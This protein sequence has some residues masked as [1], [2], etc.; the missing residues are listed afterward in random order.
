MDKLRLKVLACLLLGLFIAPACKK[1]TST[2]VSAKVSEAQPSSQ[3]SVSVFD[4]DLEAFIIDED[5]SAFGP[6]DGFVLMDESEND[7]VVEQSRHG[8][9]PIYFEFDADSMKPAQ[10]GA[11]ENNLARAKKL[12]AQ[13]KKI[14]IEGHACKFAGSAEYNMHL[15]EQRAQNVYTYFVKNGIPKDKLTVVGRGNE[16]C[17][18]PYGN[19]EQQAPNRRVEF[20]AIAVESSIVPAA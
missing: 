9:M 18:V 8:F 16:M 14:V 6:Q 13:G 19:K 17:V 1:K 20:V 7:M 10:T 3:K 12:V 2:A 11:L 4:G 5:E 15:S